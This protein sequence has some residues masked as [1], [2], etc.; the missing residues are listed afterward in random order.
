MVLAH[1]GGTYSPEIVAAVNTA[2]GALIAL[3]ANSSK[4]NGGTNS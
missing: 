3:I 1:I 4:L 2:A